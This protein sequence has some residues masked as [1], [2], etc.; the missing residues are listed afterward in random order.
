[1]RVAIMGWQGAGKGTFA[2]LLQGHLRDMNDVLYCQTYAWAKGI[3]DFSAYFGLAYKN[4]Q[5]KEATV[6]RTFKDFDLK[7]YEAV[8]DIL[9]SEDED[10]RAEFYAFGLDAVLPYVTYDA[11]AVGDMLVIS[12]RKFE[13]LIGTEVGRKVAE[14]FWV[15][16]AVKATTWPNGRRIV[17]LMDGTRFQNELD[18]CDVGFAVRRPGAVQNGEHTSEVA[19]G[20]VMQRADLNIHNTGSLEDLSKIAWE[21]A[22]IIRHRLLK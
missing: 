19:A 9:S 8:N 10:V 13:Q 14:D 2:E 11:G 5:Q 21:A 16:Q 18:V 7:W 4:H 12:P 17:V 20:L 15:Q 1:M 22:L 6:V 3:K